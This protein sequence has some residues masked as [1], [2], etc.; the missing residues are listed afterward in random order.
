[1]ITSDDGSSNIYDQPVKM[2]LDDYE[3][4]L[5]R[6]DHHIR[7]RIIQLMELF[8]HDQ[9]LLEDELTV[10]RVD[11]L[12]R[13]WFVGETK[14]AFLDMCRCRARLFLHRC[15]N[16]H[17]F[18]LEFDTFRCVFDID[19]EVAS[20]KSNEA[21]RK[22]ADGISRVH[23]RDCIQD[24]HDI[25][26]RLI[27]SLKTATM[28]FRGINV[29]KTWEREF[30][31]QEPL[32]WYIRSQLCPFMVTRTYDLTVGQ[33]TLV[34]RSIINK[35]IVSRSHAGNVEGSLAASSCGEAI[36]QKALK[37]KHFSARVLELNKGGVRMNEIINLFM[38]KNSQ[39]ITCR[40]SKKFEGRPMSFWVNMFESMNVDH[41]F[42]SYCFCISVVDDIRQYDD[43]LSVMLEN[44]H[45]S[46]V[47]DIISGL[48]YDD[49]SEV[50]IT[51]LRW[52]KFGM[53]FAIRK[54]SMLASGYNIDMITG[55][56]SNTLP[57]PLFGVSTWESDREWL[58][59]VVMCSRPRS[60][61]SA[62]FDFT[63][64]ML[65]DHDE[66]ASDAKSNHVPKELTKRKRSLD[67]DD[68]KVE[69]K[70]K[71]SRHIKS[72]NPPPA[73]QIHSK[74]ISNK[75]EAQIKRAGEHIKRLAGDGAL[76]VS[77]ISSKHAS[78]TDHPD[79]SHSTDTQVT[80][81]VENIEIF[82]TTLASV[83]AW[84]LLPR[85]SV[86]KIHVS[87]EVDP[88]TGERFELATMLL[89]MNGDVR[90][91]GK[92]PPLDPRK[93]VGLITHECF[94]SEYAYCSIVK[95]AQGVLGLG[96]AIMTILKEQIEAMR[97]V[98]YVHHRHMMLIACWM[99]MSGNIMPM[100]RNTLNEMSSCFLERSGFQAKLDA[101]SSAGTVGLV[102]SGDTRTA[103]QMIGKTAYLGSERTRV[104]IDGE[105]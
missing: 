95:E 25:V 8:D 48:N 7:A 103:E 99:A 92:I 2:K 34:C 12:S 91:G 100:H 13:D 21:A 31:F 60:S 94:E 42:S 62:S 61:V 65:T 38:Q 66:V 67:D 20:L 101:L 75:I 17:V 16:S 46:V 86:A 47:S 90:P 22:A 35:F 93:F 68:D 15:K 83:V 27:D 9:K 70:V 56:L 64:F 39:I 73:A 49:I 77:A 54:Q 45:E 79:A 29:S 104:I 89:K 59:Y 88:I 81:R 43:N 37:N 76:H 11:Q 87:Q 1:M 6:E 85:T 57:L 84:R 19:A 36:S 33:L 41:V 72:K 105:S 5:F 78:T 10:L 18:Q 30:L 71:R 82:F 24:S 52:S 51:K 55:V 58:I 28:I 44:S 3:S 50:D 32:E 40:V 4:K 26:T 63:D 14:Q 69:S 102:T 97:S 98:G 96:A 23:T 80:Q 53:K 74:R